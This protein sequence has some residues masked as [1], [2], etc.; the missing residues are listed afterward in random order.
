MR[1][2]PESLEQTDADIRTST[3]PKFTENQILTC[4]QKYN[5]QYFFFLS[6]ILV[7]IELYPQEYQ[8]HLSSQAW[9]YLLFIKGPG[10]SSSRG[11][12]FSQ[13]PKICVHTCVLK[14]CDN[15]TLTQEEKL[16]FGSWLFYYWL[17]GLSPFSDYSNKR[18]KKDLSTGKACFN[19]CSSQRETNYSALISE[20]RSSLR[21]TQPRWG[22]VPCR[23]GELH[24]EKE[25]ICLCDDFY[26]LSHRFS[27]QTPRC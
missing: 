15:I 7:V 6:G 22:F 19:P 13:G 20:R 23:K 14:H 21:V 16:N 27:Y 4:L 9:S 17:K 2:S 11:Y 18:T 1:F 24:S 10:Q 12:T 5:M 3:R 26:Y 8:H 25:T